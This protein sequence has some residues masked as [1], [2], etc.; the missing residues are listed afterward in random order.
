MFK[1][2]KKKNLPMTKELPILMGSPKK[3][4]INQSQRN[5]PFQW[6]IQVIGMILAIP[7]ELPIM[8]SRNNFGNP[9]STQAIF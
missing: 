9:K 5:S 1:K 8:G 4:N 7:K 3:K 2:N 6:G